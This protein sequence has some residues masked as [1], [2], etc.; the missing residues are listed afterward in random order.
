VHDVLLDMLG[1]DR[2]ESTQSHVQRHPD[3]IDTHLAD[4]IQQLRREVQS[5]RGRRR[6]A[7]DPG[8]NRLVTLPVVQFL[9]NI[10][11]QWHQA[12]P[13]QD[14]LKNAVVCELHN[15]ASLG[16]AFYDLGGQLP[17]ELKPFAGRGPSGPT[18]QHLP[19]AAVQ[20][21]SSRNS[22]APPV[23]ARRPSSRPE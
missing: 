17:A 5:R 20:G 11:R 14:L 1:L 13:V 9:M 21:V 22:M 4:L 12:H 16:Q 10:R 2:P 6:R 19:A 8:V 23:S 15:T 3:D 18:G 7:H